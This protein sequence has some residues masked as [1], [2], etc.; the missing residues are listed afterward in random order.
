M[1]KTID[2]NKPMIIS[3][4]TLRQAVGWLGILLP[5]VLLTGNYLINRFTDFETGCNLFKNSI[6]HYYYTRMGEVFVGTLCAVA[7]FLF[8]YKGHEKI[9][10]RLSNLAGFFALGIVIFP[11]SAVL[12]IPCNLRSYI[13]GSITGS[14]HFS[15]ATL[16]FLTLA[17][18]S[19]AVFTKNK[20]NMTPQKIIRNK[21]YKACA[22]VIVACLIG[23]VVFIQW[24]PS[25][26]NL[27]PVFCFESIALVAFGFSWLTK[28]EF[29]LK[30]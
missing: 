4:M 26:A 11:T 10:S 12:P 30:D 21:I 14:I 18:M 6:S 29:L 5:F 16:F 28:G 8:C 24:L 13:S 25:L 3:Y 7:F 17:Y 2:D 1:K 22:V 23:I 9:D 15:M 20:G 27:H 19:Y